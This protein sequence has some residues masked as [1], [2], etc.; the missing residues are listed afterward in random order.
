MQ[1]CVSGF[2][3]VSGSTDGGWWARQNLVTSSTS[4]LL[5]RRER[6]V[7]ATARRRREIVSKGLHA[8]VPQKTWDEW[9]VSTPLACMLLLGLG[10]LFLAWGLGGISVCMLLEEVATWSCRCTA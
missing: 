1:M 3:V 4:N 2:W 5:E 7:V 9:N 8:K 6:A 10:C